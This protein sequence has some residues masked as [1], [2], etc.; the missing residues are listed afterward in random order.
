MPL[1]GILWLAGAASAYF[2]YHRTSLGLNCRAV[3]GNGAV[4]SAMGID[5]RKTVLRGAVVAGV[6]IGLA[7][8]VQISYNGKVYSAS[9]LGSLATIFRALTAL[10]L[11]QSC[12]RIVNIPVGILFSSFVVTSVFN[13][14]TLFGVPSG[15]WQEV[16]LGFI[17]IAG[18]M[19]SH[20]RYK[21][22][23]K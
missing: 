19:L 10:L 16:F 17:V 23:V 13:V 11:A 4:A 14:L 18:G 9:G 5:R 2:L 6:F 21:G 7:A 15:T 8:V 3:G 1:M 12:E 20:L 22:V